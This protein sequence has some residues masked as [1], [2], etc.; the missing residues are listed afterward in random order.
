MMEPTSEVLAARARL[1]SGVGGQN[2]AWSIVAHGLVL[3]TVALWP[4]SASVAPVRTVMTVSLTGAAGPRTGGLTEIGGAAPAPVQPKPTIPV[5]PPKPQATASKPAVAPRP[6]TRT[7]APASPTRPAAAEPAPSGNAPVVT[8]AKG[9]GFG[10]SSSGGGAGR[11]VEVDVA[12]FCCP[13]YL[14]QMV[15]AIQRGWD[16]NQGVTGASVITFT[17]RRDGLVDA[18]LVRKSSGF[19]ALDNAAMRAV[20]RSERLSPLP[21]EFPN[22]SLTVH[23][24][25]EYQQ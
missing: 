24:T 19:Y 13:E 9:Q 25:F 1:Q 8:G 12:N 14:D 21:R 23:L 18:V 22:A 6:A 17:I 4:R 7:P 15:L 10:L 2:L 20:A 3:A 16:K 5:Q 11:R